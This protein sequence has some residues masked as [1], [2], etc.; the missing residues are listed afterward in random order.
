[1]A[2]DCK[3]ISC[4]RRRQSASA[5]HD[6]CFTRA[7]GKTEAICELRRFYTPRY[8]PVDTLPKAAAIDSWRR[9]VGP[10]ASF[11][12][13]SIPATWQVLWS[14]WPHDSFIMTSIL[15]TCQ[16][17]KSCGPDGISYAVLEVAMQ[18]DL[19]RHLVPPKGIFPKGPCTQLVYTLALKYL[20]RDYVKAKVYTNWAHGPLS[21]K[22]GPKPLWYL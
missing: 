21:P 16:H 22:P 11:V 20:T 1:M 17:G 4:F 6:N 2:A 7:G 14:R 15:A 3:V 10:I 9:V 8:T 18:T 12:I 19:H 5:A 13:T